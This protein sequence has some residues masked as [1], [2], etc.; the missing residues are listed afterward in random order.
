MAL[1]RHRARPKRANARGEGFK[2]VAA[3]V[4]ALIAL[5]VLGLIAWKYLSTPS[6]KAIDSSTLCPMTDPKEATFVLVDLTDP[7]PQVSQVQMDDHL[8]ALSRSTK[9]EALLEVL[10]LDPKLPEG[11]VR[12]SRCSPGDGS[13]ESSATGNPEK[14]K[15]R[16][17]K[18]F[19]E[20]FDSM[21]RTGLIGVPAEQ[22]PLIET[23]QALAVG[24][25]IKLRREGAPVHV[26]IISDMRQHSA[27]YTHYGKSLSYLRFKESGAYRNLHTDLGGADISIFYVQ[28]N[29][30]PIDESEHIQ[31]WQEWAKDNGASIERVERLQGVN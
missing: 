14:T 27:E 3:G 21:M 9:K 20:P 31:F 10:V 13:D 23:L 28:R 1:N 18:E 22:S 5:G 6:P 16:W 26:Q 15:R 4:V 19:I 11:Q 29:E 12:F 25:A 24:K 2:Y 30:P 7:L 17:Q 8:N